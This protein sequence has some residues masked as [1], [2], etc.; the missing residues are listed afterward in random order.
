LTHPVANEY[1]TAGIALDA[2]PTTFQEHHSQPLNPMCRK[3][4]N[5]PQSFVGLID[6][7]PVMN[8]CELPA[9]ANHGCLNPPDYS[10]AILPNSLNGEKTVV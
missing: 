10:W 2:Q 8:G 6:S 9:H 5:L 7:H 4:S 3:V 1:A